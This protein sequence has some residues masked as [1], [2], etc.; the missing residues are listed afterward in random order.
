MK[1][2]IYYFSGTG[3]SLAIAKQLAKDWG[4]E[5]EIQSIVECLKTRR[6]TADAAIIGLVF[7]VYFLNI[8]ELV[9]EFITKIEFKTNLYIFAVATCNTEVGFSL[10]S[11]KQILGRQGQSLAFGVAINMP[12]NGIFGKID[13][14]SP[15]D[16]QKERLAHSR[17]KVAS[18]LEMINQKHQ[19][20]IEGSDALKIHV[21]S[22]LMT[23]YIKK[24][25]RPERRFRIQN[26]C[27]GCGSC[28]Q[29]CAVK[30]IRLDSKNKPVWGENC[31]HCL[32]CFHWCPMQAI[33]M[34]EVTIGKRRYHHPEIKI[35]DM[36]TYK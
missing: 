23:F 12:G 26:N 8:P 16:V 19:G 17:L 5:V 14:T 4:D 31:A 15:L 30:N 7:P 24:I 27:T 10:F 13:K 29:V 33:N 21:V 11:I 22:F 6:L 3:N 2:V 32:A 34:D 35:G 25:Y 1:T 36:K 28:A 18:I 20:T 9:K